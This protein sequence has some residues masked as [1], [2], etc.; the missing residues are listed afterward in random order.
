MNMP[1]R[2]DEGG[3]KDFAGRVRFARR[4]GQPRQIDAYEHVWLTFD[5][6]DG[7]AE[8]RLNGQPLG[9]REGRA[10]PFEFEATEL[11]RPRNEL[12]VD[13][14]ADHPRAGLWGEVALEVRCAAFLRAVR[15]WT[16]PE[17]EARL[18]VGG[19]VVGR[20]DAPLELYVLRNNATVHYGTVLASPEGTPF[21]V[22]VEGTPAGGAVR[23]ELVNGAVV[24]YAVEPPVE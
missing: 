22:S 7:L 23:V 17:G 8:V 6:V 10:G 11:L 5:G 12:T 14:E 4:F 21:L 1:C 24:W 15:A 3:L 20:H 2:W 13:V 18:H 16:A 9:R 19:K